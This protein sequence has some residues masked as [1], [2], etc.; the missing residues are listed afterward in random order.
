MS[1]DDGVVT[2]ALLYNNDRR[3][4]IAFILFVIPVI[5]ND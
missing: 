3:E 4:T 5:F 1:H 2:A